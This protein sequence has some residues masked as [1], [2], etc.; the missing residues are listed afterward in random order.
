MSVAPAEPVLEL[1]VV[2]QVTELTQTDVATSL[3]K[4]SGER[5]CA[6]RA[7][8]LLRTAPSIP[9]ER[10][11]RERTSE[12]GEV[13]AVRPGIGRRVAREFHLTSSHAGENFREVPHEVVLVGR[14]D[15]ERLACDDLIRRLEHR[16]GH[17]G[18]IANVHERPP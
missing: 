18:Q 1:T 4:L 16:E 13:D 5:G 17:S 12:L 11:R 15:V 2:E 3:E 6:I 10:E 8:E 7:H 9:L 14:A